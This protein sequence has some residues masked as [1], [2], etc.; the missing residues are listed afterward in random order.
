MWKSLVKG[1]FIFIFF[2]ENKVYSHAMNHQHDAQEPK[3]RIHSIAH[4]GKYLLLI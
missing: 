3:S 2:L 1:K 4:K